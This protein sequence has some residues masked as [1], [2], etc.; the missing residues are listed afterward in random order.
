M[1]NDCTM[2][3]AIVATSSA[4]RRENEDLWQKP[5]QHFSSFNDRQNRGNSTHAKH[6]KLIHR[7]RLQTPSPDRAPTVGFAQ[8]KE[9]KTRK[10]NRAT[11]KSKSLATETENSDEASERT[12]WQHVCALVP[13]KSL[14]GKLQTFETSWDKDATRKMP[15]LPLTVKTKK[16]SYGKCTCLREYGIRRLRLTQMLS[17]RHIDQ[18]TPLER[19]TD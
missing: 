18:T 1:H 19:T 8:I 4:M 15:R 16:A 13:R 3:N 10:G 17:D 2:R 11:I 14:R 5:T 12:I 9:P 7:T 6:K